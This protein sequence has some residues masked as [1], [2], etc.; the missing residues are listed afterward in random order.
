M[1]R[2]KRTPRQ[3]INPLRILSPLTTQEQARIATHYLMACD[4]V[5][6]GVGTH[7]DLMSLLQLC[8]IVWVALHS[9]LFEDVDA[10][11][12]TVHSAAVALRYTGDQH[13]AGATMRLSSTGQKALQQVIS[14]FEHLHGT[15]ST[16]VFRAWVEKMTASVRAV[17]F[18]CLQPGPSQTADS[19]CMKS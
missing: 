13:P 15:V 16:K 14:I 19:K 11:L 5:R 17:N 8:E 3:V 2:K 18:Q 1:T 9:G 12:K 7:K 4:Q 6:R 10:T